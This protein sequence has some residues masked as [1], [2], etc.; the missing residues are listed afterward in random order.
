MVAF[1]FLIPFAYRARF[2]S[3]AHEPV[4]IIATTA[5]MTTP[6][7]PWQFD[8]SH[9]GR[10]IHI[11]IQ[12]A[13]CFSYVFMLLLVAYDFRAH[14]EFIARRYWVAPFLQPYRNSRFSSGK[15]RCGT[16]L[17]ARC[18]RW[19]SGDEMTTVP[20]ARSSQ[21]VKMARLFRRNST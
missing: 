11:S 20:E 21:R 14:G 7:T 5:L 8:W 4:I 18:N 2:D 10:D 1:A 13:E 15:P 16:A 3:A 6:I 9:P 12:M 19:L 17:R